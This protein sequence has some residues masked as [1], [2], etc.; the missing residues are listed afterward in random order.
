LLFDKRLIGRLSSA[1]MQEL[2]GRAGAWFHDGGVIPPT[3][4]WPRDGRFRATHSKV[5]LGPLNNGKSA[6]S[7]GLVVHDTLRDLDFVVVW[8]N[9]QDTLGPNQTP[10][11]RTFEPVATLVEATIGAFVPF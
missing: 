7:E 3:L 1:A 8:Q 10:F 11:R 9:V 6:F 4:I 5:G 2:M